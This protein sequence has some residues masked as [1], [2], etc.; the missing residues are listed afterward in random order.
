MIMDN[1]SEIQKIIKEVM[2]FGSNKLVAM[3]ILSQTNVK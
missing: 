1:Q 3:K 2:D